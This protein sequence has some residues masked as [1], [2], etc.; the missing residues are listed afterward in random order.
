MADL[1]EE[2]RKLEEALRAATREMQNYGS[3]TSDTNELLKKT[4]HGYALLRDGVKD[5]EKAV[6]KTAG[7]FGNVAAS[8]A[9]SGSSFNTLSPVVDAL[10]G[11][12]QSLAQAIPGIGG[13]ISAGIGAATQA[14]QILLEKLDGISG[15]FTQI[16]QS[17]LAGADGMTGLTRQFIESGLSLDQFTKISTQSSRALAAMSGSAFAGAERF[18]QVLGPLVLGRFSND[19]RVLGLGAEEIAETAAT[20]LTQQTR[21]GLSQGMTQRQLSE[22]TV[23]YV[24]ELDTLSKL[25]GISSREL[26]DQQL[27]MQMETRFRS[28]QAQLI[29]EQ[30]EAG[31]R[32]ARRIEDFSLSFKK[33][34]PSGQLGA[35][36]RE[37]FATGGVPMTDGAKSLFAATNGA[38]AP[39]IKQVQSGAL[40]MDEGLAQVR[41]A[42]KGNEDILITAGTLTAEGSNI[43]NQGTL[44]SM[45]NLINGIEVGT[46]EIA[47]AREKQQ[48]ETDAMTLNLVEASKA[49]ENL[50]RDIDQQFIKMLPTAGAAVKT[51]AGTLTSVIGTLEDMIQ[52]VTGTEDEPG[53]FARTMDFFKGLI[54]PG[55]TLIDTDGDGV[56]DADFDEF[57]FKA[58][59]GPVMRNKPYVVGEKGPELFIPKSSGQILPNMSG[60]SMN[61]PTAMLDTA[62]MLNTATPTEA[63]NTATAGR[64][65]SN[66]LMAEQNDKLDELITVVKQ[67]KNIHS[68][69]LS[70]S[71]S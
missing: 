3:L 9:R 31:Q 59:G 70:A 7:A 4:N 65:D 24:K 28:R 41:T 23:T 48:V 66:K 69:M 50:A 55:N 36:I 42:L 19:L 38:I 56:G 16:G 52:A 22:A 20:F 10:G 26:Q 47:V 46:K 44:A 51:F 17:G 21:L 49:M 13:Y 39:I 37:L 64:D 58:K 32:A 33:Y 62:P 14:G 18:S 6:L 53:Y 11:A 71:Y 40:S 67:S 5:T 35:Q 27:Q 1:E 54:G 57:G 30:G 2:Q 68:K 29:N 15:S 25:T 63:A 61:T 8:V 43:I 45:Q 60:P 12:M 34:D